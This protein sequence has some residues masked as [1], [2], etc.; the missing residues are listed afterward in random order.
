[1]YDKAKKVAFQMGLTTSHASSSNL[2]WR[3]L[4]RIWDQHSI[5]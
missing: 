2:P 4:P 3:I 1:V 5:P